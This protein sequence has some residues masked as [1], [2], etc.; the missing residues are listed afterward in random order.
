V[1]FR[2]D[3][4]EC[5][6]SPEHYRASGLALLDLIQEGNLG[7]MRAVEKYDWRKGFRFST[8]AAWWIRLAITGG[9]ANTRRTIRLPLRAND[10]VAR[11]HKARSR[12]EV[13][14]GRPAT[15]AELSVDV[16]M[17]LEMAQHARFSV[18]TGVTVYF[19][20]PRSPWQRGT[21]ENTNGL[22][23]QYFPKCSD[24]RAHTQ[25]DLD[26]VAAELNNRP[27]Q[28]LGWLSPSAVR[29]RRRRVRERP[30]SHSSR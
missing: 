10:A 7:L 28:T 14:L 9:I 18:D 15:L 22:L 4:T 19:C 2:R 3:P 5:G 11:L 26:A 1:V 27:R 6:K 30:R 16:E 29:T 24:L 23:R 13:E 12:L 8:Y 20:D 21:N 25:A 17:P